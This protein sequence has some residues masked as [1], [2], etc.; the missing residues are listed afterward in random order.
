MQQHQLAVT[1]TAHYTTLGRPGPHVRYL[2][3]VCHGYGQLARR[4]IRP[5]SAI[6]DEATL[7]VAPE[8]LSRFYWGGFDGPVVASWMTR[9]DRLDEIADYSRMLSQ[10][11]DLYVPQCHPE[12]RIILFG[13]SQG[14][15]TVVRWMMRAFPR[16]DQLLLWAGQLPED[17]DYRPHLDYF[18]GKPIHFAYGDA[19]PFITPERLILMRRYLDESGLAYREFPFAGAHDVVPEALRE[20]WWE[21]R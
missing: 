6:Q 12:V 17:I 18:Q 15:A 14:T 16:F 3:V 1:R 20:W 5:F 21:V 9:E 10:L 11:Y 19:D 2:W 13:F 4:F 8:G 7:V